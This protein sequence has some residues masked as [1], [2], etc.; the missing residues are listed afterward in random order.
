MTR[1]L[2]VRVLFAIAFALGASAAGAGEAAVPLPPTTTATPPDPAP[3]I[4]LVTMSPGIEYW[5]RF[6]HN[7]ILVDEGA[8]RTLYNFGYFDFGQEDFLL[9]F[10][11]GRMLYQ[12]VALP[13]ELDLRGYAADGRGVRLQW[14]AI[15]PD[16]ARALAASLAWNARPENAEYRYDYFTANCSTKVRDALDA[17]LDGALRRELSGRSH[18]YTFRDEARRLAAPLP[19]LYLGIHLGLGPFVDKPTSL[20]EEA[21]V[22]E[23]LREAVAGLRTPDGG[24][25]VTAEVELLPQR[26]P[27]PGLAPPDWRAWFLGSGLMLAGALLF[28]AHR[29]APRALR[30][31]GAAAAAV[32]WLACGLVGCGLVALWVLTDH[33]AAWGN[34]NALLFNPLCLALLPAALALWRGAVLSSTARRIAFVVAGCAGFAF[35]L[36]FLPFRIQS[37]GD[38]IALMLPIHAALAWRLRA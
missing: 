11:R 35:F 6:G 30:H 15:E 10:L 20:W 8:R 17:A 16:A 27:L 26:L 38:W 2:A 1:S 13:L 4:G 3:R 31:F 36:K 29:S 12:L 32:L 33:V 24:P 34:E 18:G 25:L 22:P 5:S 37:N 23:R 19:W 28:A 9:R 14:L 21:F 7:A